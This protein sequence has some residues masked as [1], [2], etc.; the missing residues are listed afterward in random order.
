[1]AKQGNPSMHVGKYIGT[2][3]VY[4]RVT[5]RR[6]IRVIHESEVTI[7]WPISLIR[8]SKRETRRG[9]LIF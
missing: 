5:V 9:A 6:R 1:M 8:S 7:K 2:I 4:T 3:G